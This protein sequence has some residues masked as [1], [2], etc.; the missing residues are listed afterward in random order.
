MGIEPFLLG[1]ISNV[2]EATNAKM[3]PGLRDGLFQF[4]ATSIVNDL[5]AI[6]IERGRD[7]GLGDYNEVPRRARIGACRGIR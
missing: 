5:A 4:G 2:Q 7:I 1:L 6:D 3:V